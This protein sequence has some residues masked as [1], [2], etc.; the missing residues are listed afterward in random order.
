MSLLT[1]I[2]V[3][4]MS[5]GFAACS[6]SDDDPIDDGKGIVGTWYLYM[7]ERTVAWKFES[8]G[9]CLYTEWEKNSSEDWTYAETGTWKISGNKLTIRYDY[10]DF[11]EDTFYYSISDGGKT[12]TLSDDYGVCGT[13]KKK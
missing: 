7:T 2:M 11:D 13:Y 10:G 5:V 8:N 9:K 12:L 3:A 6:K 1:I 4:F